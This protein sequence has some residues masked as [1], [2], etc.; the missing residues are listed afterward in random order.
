[1]PQYIQPQPGTHGPG[2]DQDP[3]H[4]ERMREL[5][6]RERHLREKEAAA[7][8]MHLSR[9]PL[10]SGYGCD[11]TL[12]VIRTDPL[13]RKAY[14]LA[15]VVGADSKQVETGGYGSFIKETN[16]LNPGK[17]AE[18]AGLDSTRN[19]D[20]DILRR[21]YAR[22]L[23]EKE[24]GEGPK[25]PTTTQNQPASKTK[26]AA[27]DSYTKEQL[28]KAV[29][30]IGGTIGYTWAE[31]RF[32]HMAQDHGFNALNEGTQ[33]W[34]WGGLKDPEVK[35]EM[36]P[37]MGMGWVAGR[38]REYYDVFFN[39]TKMPRDA[40]SATFGI[41]EVNKDITEKVKVKD[42]WVEDIR[43]KGLR[44]LL[45]QTY[46]YEHPAKFENRTLR[47]ATAEDVLVNVPDEYKGENPVVVGCVN[48]GR[49]IGG[50]RFS[51]FTG[52]VLP[53]SLGKALHKALE[54]KRVTP[55]EA[56][57]GRMP[58]DIRGRIFDPGY[59]S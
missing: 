44:G 1:M 47:K 11:E 30:E 43:K 9:G 2:H 16:A 54:D 58:D 24:R 41:F 31:E 23:I 8:T 59:K 56:F 25:Q 10:R 26:A 20:A 49:L 36:K 42:A 29:T 6:E 3:Q 51:E 4:Q 18:L 15:Y 46:G 34:T 19:P 12:D 40:D 28:L 33:N 22:L 39:N 37:T 53:V 7:K 48:P 21:D 13:A 45:G 14:A 52:V 38:I 55:E 27:P 5:A 50:R 57:G 35:M 17:T 32:V